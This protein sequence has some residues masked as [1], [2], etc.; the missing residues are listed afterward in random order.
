MN[1]VAGNQRARRE[2]YQELARRD[3]DLARLVAGGAA[4][5]P[6][7]WSVLEDTAGGDAFREL[8]LHIVS[9]QIS[10]AAALTI[11]RRL[12]DTLGGAVAPWPILAAPLTEL[13]A[14][15]L[16]GAK[17]TSLR[18][19]AE[20]V[21]DGRLSFARLAVSDD[22][23]AQAE[24]DAVRG[25][26]PWSAQMFL[27]HHLRRPDVF[28]AADVG[29]QR[30]AQSAFGLAQRP[31]EA[32]LA[33]R[34]ER[35][36]PYRSYAAALLWTHAAHHTAKERDMKPAVILVHGA[37][38][39][40]SSWN[41]VAAPLAAEG[42]R[43]I[44]WANPL[45]SVAADAAALTG[46]VRSVDGPLVLAGHSYGGAVITNVDADAGDIRAL[47]YIAGFAL[48]AGESPG[49]ASSL[50]PGSTLAETL[51]R[52]RL[53]DGGTDTYI[54]QDKFHHQ[55]AAD[56]PGQQS[57]LMAITQRPITEAA[58][59]EPSGD[60]PLWRSVPSWFIFGELDHNIP[61]GAH[62]IMAGRA[63]A[64]RTIEV[65]GASHVVGVSHPAETAQLVFEAAGAHAIA[66]T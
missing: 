21:L 2:V 40:S 49:D 16:S 35:W 62:R 59:F 53:A 17:A 30:A 65:P 32:E 42:H 58:L 19:L 41:G 52:V 61:A 39:D 28:P 20:R 4:P 26:G 55:F 45:R 7:A 23:S 43:V 51:E 36:R 24:L 1:A 47:V 60:R 33:A 18:D 66:T 50:A 64:Q 56:L 46:L 54:A 38:A 15:G 27:L 25:V 37:Y 3:D 10:T 14:T 6:F 22:P 5:D 31:T 63:D 12:R 13:R 57:A 34:A 8:V 29:L 9:Q 44:A 48:E 11:F